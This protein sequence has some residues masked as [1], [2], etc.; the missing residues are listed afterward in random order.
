MV[1]SMGTRAAS[2][3]LTAGTSTGGVL[4][5][6][7]E[8]GS[9]VRV[10][11]ARPECVTVEVSPSSTAAPV[12][13]TDP[14]TR[15]TVTLRRY[16]VQYRFSGG[17]LYRITGAP[18]FDVWIFPVP[19]PTPPPRPG[20]GC[21]SLLG[22]TGS[23]V[24][25]V[26]GSFRYADDRGNPTN[27]PARVRMVYI[28]Y[29]S[30]TGSSGS[31]GTAIGG[32]GFS[33]SRTR[34]IRTPSPPASNPDGT[35]VYR[36]CNVTSRNLYATLCTYFYYSGPRIYGGQA[37]GGEA[38]SEIWRRYAGGG[39]IYIEAP[40]TRLRLGG[41]WRTSHSTP[42][43]ATPPIRLFLNPTGTWY[44]PQSYAPGGPDLIPRKY[45]PAP[46]QW[47][48]L[49]PDTG[50]VA[51]RWVEWAYATGLP[52]LGMVD[53]IYDCQ[54]FLGDPGGGYDHPAPIDGRGCTKFAIFP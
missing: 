15:R 31:S 16:H 43:A 14:V 37:Y 17:V 4:R 21:L 49:W 26:D 53:P 51:V 33:A 38:W 48:W 24:A 35:V 19:G 6:M 28:S 47:E 45:G 9:A 23:V 41:Y 3:V 22:G 11:E 5:A 32:S 2:S 39:A 18:P 27:D 54:L 42:W 44:I 12:Q 10:V 50:R 40:G 1:A 46:W 34:S 13:Y 8:I 30:D 25:R 29:R 20:Q 36:I 52:D 7:D